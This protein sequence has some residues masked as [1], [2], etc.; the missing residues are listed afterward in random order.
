MINFKAFTL[1]NGLRVLVHEDQRSTIAV[2]NIMY[3]VGSRDEN[4]DKTGLAHFFEHLMFGGSQHVAAYDSALQKVGGENNAYTTT[5]VTNYYCTLPAVNL[6]TA[7]W[8]ESDRMLGLSFDLNVLEIQRRVVMEE[9][10]E[11]YLNQPYGDVW[12]KLCALAYKKHPYRWPTIGRD[13]HHIAQLTM[14]DVKEFFYKFYLPNNAVLVV[15]GGVKTAQVER[16][17][18][19]WFAPIPSGVVYQRNLPQEPMQ[20]LGRQLTTAA[21]V[22]LDAIYKAYHMPAR[23]AAGYHTSELLG[24]ILGSGESSRFYTQLIKKKQ[25]FNDI[26]VY[27][28]DAFDP[29]LFVISGR[30]NEHITFEQAEEAIQAVI[31]DLQKQNVME[32]ELDKVKN[33]AEAHW[34]FSS[35]DVAYRAEALATAALLGNPYLVNHEIE[36]IRKVTAAEIGH[37]SNKLLRVDRASTLY[38]QQQQ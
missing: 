13:M 2:V 37:M 26:Y 14:E 1:A 5:D 25:Y 23:S 31:N 20:Q 22:P 24:D 21:N 34:V 16:L 15:A 28:T 29:G 7:F 38:Y 27:V 10:R 12:L 3:H 4:K 32:K 9:F 36:K 6:E 30:L 8:L 18:K 19:K 17:C 33:Q 11:C 35:V